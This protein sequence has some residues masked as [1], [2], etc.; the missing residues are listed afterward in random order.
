MCPRTRIKIKLVLVELLA[1]AITDIHEHTMAKKT[2][3]EWNSQSD[4]KF[5]NAYQTITDYGSCCTMFPY[6][7]FVN[8]ETIP[9][10]PSQYSSKH[11]HSIPYGAKNGVKRGMKLIIDVESY[12]YAYYPRGSKG[13]KVALK[14]ARDKAVISQDGFYVA[15]G[16]A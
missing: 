1:G 5:Y 4:L 10:D 13:V 2:F 12:D 7:D 16:L 9:I 15:P 6:L 11:Y 8:N 3:S 14:D